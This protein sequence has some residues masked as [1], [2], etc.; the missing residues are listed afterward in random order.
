[1]KSAGQILPQW[2]RRK[3]TSMSALM[4]IPRTLALMAVQRQITAL[5]ST[6]PSWSGQDWSLPTGRLNFARFNMLAADKF[7]FCASNGHEPPPDGGV[8]TASLLGATGRVGVGQFG[9]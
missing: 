6:S 9:S 7:S 5:R 2:L 4:L 3:H 1:V 8:G